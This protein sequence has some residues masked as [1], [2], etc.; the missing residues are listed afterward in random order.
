MA[1]VGPFQLGIYSDSMRSW[2]LAPVGWGP[3]LAHLTATAGD[4]MARYSEI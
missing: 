1:L 3:G 2:K 4:S